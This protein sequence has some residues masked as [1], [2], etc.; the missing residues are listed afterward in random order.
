LVKNGNNPIKYF[1]IL[2]THVHATKKD[3]SLRVV[4]DFRELNAASHGDRYSMKTV[5]E[6]SE[7]IGREGSTTTSGKMPLEEQSR[8]PMAF[9]IPRLGQLQLVV[10]P[11]GLLGCPASFQRLIELAMP[12]LVNV[13][14]DLLV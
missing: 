12:G 8:H 4:Q 1:K 11:V 5:N 7:E 2:L 9:W 3:R 14:N 10:K 13:V 6:C